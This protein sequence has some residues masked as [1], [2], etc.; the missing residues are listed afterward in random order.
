MK[1]LMLA[2]NMNIGG[3]ETH[4]F[5]LSRLLAS[6]GHEVTVA[7]AGGVTADRLAAEGVTHVSLPDAVS[8]AATKILADLIRREKPHVVHAHT[9][10]RAFLCRVLLTGFDFPL[11]FTAHALFSPRFPLDRL[12]FFPP[13]TIAVSCDIAEHLCHRLG[14]P[15]QNVTVIENGV[16]TTR[17][18]PG[19]PNRHRP[20]TVLSISRQDRDCALAATLLCQL[21]PLLQ[22][23]LGGPLRVLIAGGGNA[24]PALRALAQRA[25]AACDGEVIQ[26]LGNVPDTAPL[27]RQCDLFVGVSRAAME[28]MATA[29]P[30]ILCGNQ[31]YLGI[32]NQATLPEAAATNLCARGGPSATAE[33]LLSDLL[34]VANSTPEARA[35]LGAFGRETVCRRYSVDVMAARTVAVYERARERFCADRHTDAVLCG[36]YGYSNCG[37]ELILRH[38]VAAQKSRRDTVRLGVMTATGEAPEGTVGIRRYRPSA[39]VRELR[40]S[41]A[42]ILGGGSLLQD[43]TSRRSLIYYLSLIRAAGRMGLPV[44][45]Y[46]NGLGPLSPRAER[47]CRKAFREVDVISLRDRDSWNMV[48]AMNLPNTKVVLGADPV[49]DA[50]P[51]DEKSVPPLRRLALFPR[52]GTRRTDELA[53]AESVAALAE[54]QGVDVAV[55]AMNPHEDRGTVRRITEQL[56]SRLAGTGLHVTEASSDPDAIVRLIGRSSLVVSERLHALILAFRADVPC[57]GI[58][59]DPKIG[60]FLREIGQEHRLCASVSP[61]SII[62]C[63]LEEENSPPHQVIAKEMANRAN[64]DAD[65]AHHLIFRN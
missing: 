21:A 47:L 50:D 20:F 29:K 55:A 2:D 23:R 28:A 3:A 14:V 40:K 8:P 22:K 58:D 51:A 57:I 61:Q 39:V 38:I 41:G 53:L 56:S 30:V 9:R 5:E 54:H 35:A 4:L 60:A 52:S 64:T 12:S 24:L 1:I 6:R 48:R 49:L 34:T 65:T 16:D 10:R 13:D 59:R 31:G 19:A 36:Y 27:Y 62:S 33:R 26:L 45:L 46:A 37:D 25:N 15:Q 32:L 18:S 17:F 7:S 44:M 43:A 11:V 63:A 42:L